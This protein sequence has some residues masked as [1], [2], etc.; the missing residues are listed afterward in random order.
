MGC[1]NSLNLMDLLLGRNAVEDADL[2]SSLVARQSRLNAL[3]QIETNFS[4][5]DLKTPALEKAP[6]TGR[7]KSRFSAQNRR[8]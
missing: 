7:S 2:R 1:V 8:A 4:Q 3:F 6:L 5:V